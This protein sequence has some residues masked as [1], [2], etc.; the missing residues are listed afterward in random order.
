M[1]GYFSADIV[2]SEKRTVFRELSSRKAERFEEQIMSKD[3]NVTL[4]SS[5]M[6]ATMF[7]IFQI[8]LQHAEQN[9]YEQLTVKDVYTWDVDFSALFSVLWYDFMNKQA[10]L[11]L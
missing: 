11:I 4:F 10:S 2:C 7:I 9:V 8:F 5:Q 3:K 6:E 1:L